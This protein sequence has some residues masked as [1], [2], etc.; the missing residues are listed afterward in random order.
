M[1]KREKWGKR[2]RD[3]KGSE[4]WR[5]RGGKEGEMDD[6]HYTCAVIYVHV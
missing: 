1:T 2:R 5:G 3:R 6:H 4:K